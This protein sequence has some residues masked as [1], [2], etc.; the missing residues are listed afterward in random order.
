VAL[1]LGDAQRA[2]TLLSAAQACFAQLAPFLPPADEATF[3]GLIQMAQQALPQR[4]YA[5]AWQ[6]GQSMTVA[7]AMALAVTKG[8]GYPL[9]NTPINYIDPTE[10]VAENDWE[11]LRHPSQ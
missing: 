10:P 5:A 2:T 1:A 4:Q 3:N 7:E 11:V 6:A 8:T 9:Q